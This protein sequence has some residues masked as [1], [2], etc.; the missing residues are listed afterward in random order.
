M[1]RHERLPSLIRPQL[2]LML[3]TSK[4]IAPSVGLYQFLIEIQSKSFFCS[5]MEELIKALDK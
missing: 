3:T 5:T 1:I 2:L 4:G